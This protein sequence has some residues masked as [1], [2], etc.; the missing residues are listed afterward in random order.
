[1]CNENKR[2]YILGDFNLNLLDMNI[3]RNVNLLVETMN[4]HSF[5]PII[6][7]PTRIVQ[8]CATL[9]DNIFT[10]DK[11]CIVKSGILI[12]DISDHLPIFAIT[13]ADTKLRNSLSPESVCVR[14][15]SEK[16]YINFRNHLT[17]ASWES[18]LECSTAETAYDKF[19]HI[20][21]NI[22]DMSFPIIKKKK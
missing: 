22:F 7:K 16:N 11:D 5:F 12:A 4:A 19:V 6:M 13:K 20:L 9:I 10:D 15:M 2:N 21:K 1:M 8:S 17:K 3:N 14:D 18:V